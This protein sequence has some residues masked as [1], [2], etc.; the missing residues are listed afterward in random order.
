MDSK[1]DK[2]KRKQRRYISKQSRT[3]PITRENETTAA[4]TDCT[5]KPPH[6]PLS[7]SVVP[8][9]GQYWCP[10]R[11]VSLTN[12][13]KFCVLLQEHFFVDEIA[14]W[15]L[16]QGQTT[17]FGESNGH[18]KGLEKCIFRP[19]PKIAVDLLYFTTSLGSKIKILGC[20]TD[21]KS[22][23]EDL[24]TGALSSSSGYQEVSGNLTTWRHTKWAPSQ[25]NNH[26]TWSKV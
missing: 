15:R 14:L 4:N 10:I 26:W 2:S 16:L 1:S 19:E 12:N 23:K 11:D 3:W 17:Y 8:T 21:E 13:G 24:E 6:F 22:I 7:Y 5:A 20:M 25:T 18:F 9:E